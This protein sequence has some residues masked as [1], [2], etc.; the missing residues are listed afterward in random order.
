MNNQQPA[1]IAPYSKSNQKKKQSDI[2]AYVSNNQLSEE[3]ELQLLR[4]MQQ[5]EIMKGIMLTKEIEDIK[6]HK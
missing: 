5:Q 6:V 4:E 1:G 2:S 3:Q